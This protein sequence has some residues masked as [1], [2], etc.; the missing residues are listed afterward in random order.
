[1][2]NFICEECLEVL[3]SAHKLRDESLISDRYFR[4]C[5]ES[6]NVLEE[7]EEY[8]VVKRET[9]EP[10]ILLQKTTEQTY[11]EQWKQPKQR[12]TQSQDS[13]SSEDFNYEVDCFKKG[14]NKSKAWDYFG[15]LVHTN[16]DLVESEADYFFCRLCVS[17]KKTIKNRYKSGSISTGMIFT[18][19]KAAHQIAMGSRTSPPPVAKATNDSQNPQILRQTFTC[20]EDNC[21][22]EFIMK[23]CLDIHLGLE[24]TGIADEPPVNTEFLV[25]LSQKE[26]RSTS[27]AWNYFG[28]LL[29]SNN[30]LIDDDHYYCRLCVGI[31]DLVKYNKS[32]STTT[33]FHHLRAQHLHNTRK[34]K[35]FGESD[36][37]ENECE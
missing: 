34:R 31:G 4:D 2:P 16:G 37:N 24:H 6:E 18:H 20:P 1:M 8:S 17:E 26:T 33:L 23:M 7:E 3:L 13:S 9:F 12:N 22:K 5:Y 25:D 36:V 35:R 11:T 15:R 21:G 28:F 32:C 10:P 30:A 29:D 14:G 27:M 19:L